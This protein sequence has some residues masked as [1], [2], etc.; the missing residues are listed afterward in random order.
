[1][2]MSPK[3]H[4]IVGA[5]TAGLNAVRTLRQLGDTNQI[6]LVSAEEPYSRMVLPYYLEQRI[7]EAHTATATPA[8]LDKWG[9]IRHFGRRAVGL[10]SKKNKL[11]LDNETELEYDNLLIA[12]GSS[13]ARP[14]IPGANDPSLY[15]FWT[16]DDARGVSH[17]IHPDAHV[18]VVGA[19][20]IAFTI[21][22]GLIERSKNLTI[23]EAEPR[24]L[25]RM[26]NDGG[27]KLVAEWLKARGVK[28]RTGAKIKRIEQKGKKHVLTFS[29][30]PAL[31]ADLVVMATGIRTNLDWLNGAGVKINQAIVV[32]DRM[33]SNVPNVF[34]AGDV[35]EGPNLITGAKEVHAIEPTA[36][37]HGRVAAANMAGRSVSYPGSLLMNIVTVAG[38][39]V[40]SFGSWGEKGAEVVEGHAAARSAYRK[41]LFKGDRMIGAIMVGPHKE[42]WSEND[43]GMI[44]GLI[45][46]GTRLGEWKKFLREHPFQIK[47][48]F[49]ATQTVSSL[50]P[51]TV[52]GHPSPPPGA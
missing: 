30:G 41:Y 51:R 23:I 40:A 1:M 22:N 48:P 3:R 19:G 6:D 27:A 5:G 42:T 28:M 21:L 10:D 47:K 36:M 33:R 25:P 24:I 7:S 39:D 11:R 18:V 14:R 38:L 13:A 37:E 50:L 9:V 4:V 34:A 45:Q 12:T 26:I 20:F 15:T 32:D 52:L 35:A 16:L 49:L 44:K 8:M 17:T 46:A 29:S 43:L 31:S 2:Q